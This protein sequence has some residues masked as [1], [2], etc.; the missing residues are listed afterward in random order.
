MH[1]P[2]THGRKPSRNSVIGVDGCR[3]GWV[4]ARR[5]LLTGEIS[6]SIAPDFRNVVEAGADAAMTIVDMP[7]GLTDSGR[8]ACEQLARRLLGSPRASSVFPTPRRPML[9][10]SDYA[11]AN[12]W[13]KAQGKQ[14]GGGLPK[15]T[16][17]ILPRIREIDALITP[18]HQARLGEGHPEVAFARL[19]GAKACLH[20]KRKRE[21]R[22]VRMALL[23]RHGVDGLSALVA[24]AG[25][26]A[27][28][29]D[30][31]DAIAL[32]LTAEARLNGEALRLT[33]EAR[34]ARGLVMEIWG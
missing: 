14:N 20:S 16:W 30:V 10:F 12:A 8:R 7:I 29:D 5:S 27:K 2:A 17:A 23:T 21:G 4:M 9:D 34:D 6:V 24:G 25:R 28:P 31:F 18:A 15:Q 11:A 19:N 32:S 26:S 13:G 1:M 22:E 33:D 3:G